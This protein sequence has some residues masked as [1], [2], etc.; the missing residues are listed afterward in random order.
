M[1]FPTRVK[2]WHEREDRRSLAQYR[3]CSGVTWARHEE[4]SALDGDQFRY[5]TLA[6]PPALTMTRQVMSPG[7]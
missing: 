6:Q 1:R 7:R 5:Q 3:Q 4:V 2:P